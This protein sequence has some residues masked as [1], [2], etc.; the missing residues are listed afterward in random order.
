MHQHAENRLSELKQQETEAAAVDGEKI[1]IEWAEETAD[2]GQLERLGDLVSA[3]YGNDFMLYLDFE[4]QS[5]GGPHNALVRRVDGVREDDFDRSMGEEF[6]EELDVN[7]E[8]YKPFIR[9]FVRA[10]VEGALSVLKRT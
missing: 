3:P 1:G 8:F 5:W 6:W 10:F 4:G 2:W 9:E 7:I